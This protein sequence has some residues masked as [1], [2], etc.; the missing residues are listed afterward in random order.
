MPH[1]TQMKRKRARAIEAVRRVDA[2]RKRR[3][4]KALRMVKQESAK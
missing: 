2:A 1:N 4:A 3:K